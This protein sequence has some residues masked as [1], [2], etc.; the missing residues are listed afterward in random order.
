MNSGFDAGWEIDLFGGTRRSIEAA[1]ADLA[2][3]R[4]NLCDVLVSLTAEVALNYL[5]IR[6]TQKRLSVAEKNLSAQQEAFEFIDWRYQAG[7]SNE[8]APPAGPLQP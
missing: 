3:S 5:D 6:T 4:E 2:A 7:L 8:L 1:E